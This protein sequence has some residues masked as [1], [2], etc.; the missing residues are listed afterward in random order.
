MADRVKPMYEVEG[1]YGRM[2]DLSAIQL[3][4]EKRHLFGLKKKIKEG[5][6][7]VL[8]KKTMKKL[9]RM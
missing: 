5:K 7:I 1:P 2:V 8:K 3:L 9:M 6:K 4:E